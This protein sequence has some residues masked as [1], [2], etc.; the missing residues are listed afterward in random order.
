MDYISKLNAD[1]VT[2]VC[3]AISGKDFKKLFQKHSNEFT[4]IC[5][6]RVAKKLPD[7]KAV[8][9]AVE[10]LSKPLIS[11][12]INNTLKIW[13]TTIHDHIKECVSNGAQEEDALLRVLP[14]CP[15]HSHLDMYFKLA[16]IDITQDRL[17]LLQSAVNLLNSHSEEPTAATDDDGETDI[18]SASYTEEKESWEKEKASLI[19]QNADL[20]ERAEAAEA[21]VT[22]A[23]GQLDSLSESGEKLMLELND[24]RKRAQRRPNLGV[25]CANEAY[26]F[27]SICSVYTDYNGQSRLT[28]LFDISDERVLDEFS[29]IFPI[30]SKLYTN[31]GPSVDDFVGIWNWR[32][33]PNISD[34]TKDF[35]ETAYNKECW[36]TE[37][38]VLEGCE[39]SKDIIEKLKAGIPLAVLSNHLVFACKGKQLNEYLGLLCSA[40]ELCSTGGTVTIKDDVMSIPQYSFAQSDL[41]AYKS[42]FFLKYLD[43][44]IPELIL[45]VKDPLEIVKE[46]VLKRITWANAKQRGFVKAQYQQIRTFLS[47]IPTAGICSD[48]ASQAGCSEERSK[49]LFAEFKQRASKYITSGNI[50]NDILRGVVQDSPEFVKRCKQML[51]EEWEEE[52]KARIEAAN[53][54]VEKKSAEIRGKEEQLSVLNA[55]YSEKQS[56]YEEIKAF[57]DKREQLA[58][59]VERKVEERISSAKRNAAD[60]IAE[61]AFIQKDSENGS[62]HEEI[63]FLAG[64]ILPQDALTINTSWREELESVCAELPEAGVTAKFVPALATFLYSA[65]LNRVPLMLMGPNG[66]AIADAFSAALFGETCAQLIC[67]GNYNHSALQRTEESNAQIVVIDNVF[68]AKWNYY[69][70][71]YSQRSSK[72]LIAVNPFAEDLQIEPRGIVNY[73]IPVMTELFVDARPSCE[74]VGGKRSEGFCAYP[75]ENAKPYHNKL[76]QK[77]HLSS[78]STKTLQ[79]LLADLHS[80]NH[81]IQEEY[82]YLFSA[83]PCAYVTNAMDTLRE[84]IEGKQLASDMKD[85]LGAYLGDLE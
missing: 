3:E 78:L 26:P 40:Q 74:F 29:E 22:N 47:E 37:V 68:D 5:P 45:D 43:I 67:E 24:L 2:Y 85:I 76:F 82:D 52:Y 65:Y 81:N 58:A 6:G 53:A 19:K 48:I 17:H 20:R 27:T 7:E 70:N 8:S 49:E 83:L 38:V 84:H 44:G 55:D 66:K 51:T 33:V 69:I 28:R 56:Q 79:Q 13:L 36:P 34:P 46:V 15:F 18:D 35:I 64:Q 4:R 16:D 25:S 72:F 21:G 41:I 32:T 61:Q 62:I 14:E 1:E 54:A 80:M 60:F 11:S 10:N 12:F 39:T 71:N 63:Q 9:I 30:Y 75:K 50:E 31:D 77:L 57:L 73:W 42:R 59:D 23:Q